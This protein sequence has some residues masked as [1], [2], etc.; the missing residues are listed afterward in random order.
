MKS[1]YLFFSFV[2]CSV[3]FGKL[4]A[5]PIASYS[6]ASTIETYTPISD[7]SVLGDNANDNSVFNNVPLGFTFNFGGVDYSDCSVSSNGYLKFGG[8][9]SGEL[10]FYPLTDV[11][12]QEFIVAPFAY[13]LIPNSG[14]EMRYRTSG[15]APDRV[16]TLQWGDYNA[17]FNGDSYNFQIQ[18][19]EAGNEID[20]NYGNFM[21]M[22]AASYVQVGL[23]GN[24]AANIMDIHQR[25]IEEAD[26]T[27]N[28][29]TLAPFD[30]GYAMVN[31]ASDPIFKPAEGLVFTFTP[32]AACTGTPVAGTLEA[33]STVLCLG[34]TAVLTS[35]GA[36]PYATGLSYQWQFSTDD[37]DWITIS[38]Q[39]SSSYAFQFSTPGFYR[40]VLACG[41]QSDATNSIE[42]SA[43][44]S[45]I[46]ANAPLTELFNSTWESRCGV[47]NVPNAENWDANGTFSQL[48]WFGGDPEGFFMPPFNGNAAIFQGINSNGS[49]SSDS[50]TGDLDLYLDLS[51][52][53]SFNLSFYFHYA[54]MGDTLNVLFSADGGD[55]FT[56][57]SK[58]TTPVST[59]PWNQHF[60]NLGAPSSAECVLRLRGESIGAGAYMAVDNLEIFACSPPDV[61]ITSD[62]ELLCAGSAATLTATPTGNVLW[63]TGE[64]TSVISVSPETTAT[65]SVSVEV[66]GCA[67]SSQYIQLVDICAGTSNRESAKFS[68]VYPNPTA[69]ELRLDISKGSARMVRIFDIAGQ[70][71]NQFNIYG[72][73][74]E[75][76]IETLQS[77]VYVLEVIFENGISESHRVVK[78]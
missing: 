14:G 59:D 55:S 39:L 22:P 63:S 25:Q 37:T 12:S 33:E 30:F 77:G 4:F 64:T 44:A 29:S 16:F 49:S 52:G 46:A 32:S 43:V 74:T 73:S 38:T 78:F 50:F 75:L 67:G 28:T 23:R 48:A 36:I 45:N 13:Y 17:N 71:I 58:L 15:A 57:L 3:A 7:G 31:G 62:T 47:E 19:N 18:L 65:Y 70:Q 54:F 2:F 51:S 9:L 60:I 40:L 10:I 68:K 11:F 76:E 24:L 20:F 42:I 27:W 5:Q 66:E 69:S 41:G 56:S 6:F 61:N 34:E 21:L 35:T 8:D 1:F 26:N 53:E 72:V